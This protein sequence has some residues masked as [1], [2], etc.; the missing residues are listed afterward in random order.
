MLPAVVSFFIDSGFP[1]SS[2]NYKAF[3]ETP[4]PEPQTYADL[5]KRTHLG[6][7][8]VQ[9]CLRIS[10]MNHQVFFHIT[11]GFSMVLYS[12][13]VYNIRSNHSKIFPKGIFEKNRFFHPYVGGGSFWL[14]LSRQSISYI[15]YL[16]NEWS[17]RAGIGPIWKISKSSF[18]TSYNFLN[19]V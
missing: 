11:K 5:A 19:S 18:H 6:K 8:R 16:P 9:V 1:F 15:K 10:P 3:K 2:Y 13:G 7:A 4:Y 14:F 17:Y 12:V